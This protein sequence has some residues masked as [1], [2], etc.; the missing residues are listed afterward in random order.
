M[1]WDRGIGDKLVDYQINP[2]KMATTERVLDET[3]VM[4]RCWQ[5]MQHLD[6]PAFRRATCW[7]EDRY[8][9]AEAKA[10]AKAKEPTP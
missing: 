1:K 3:E 4:A 6:R 9:D 10:A 7:L 8:R 2:M 5:M